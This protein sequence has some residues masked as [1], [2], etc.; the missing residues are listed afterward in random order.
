MMILYSHLLATLKV[1]LVTFTLK[2]KGNLVSNQCFWTVGRNQTEKANCKWDMQHTNIF[3][4]L[5]KQSNVHKIF[6]LNLEEITSNNI[7]LFQTIAANE[8]DCQK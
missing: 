2:P 7:L 5:P 3:F 1:T 6:Y 4:F 8:L